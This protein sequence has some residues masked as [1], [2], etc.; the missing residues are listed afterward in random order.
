MRRTTTSLL[1]AA[2][3]LLAGAARPAVAQ[4]SVGVPP[5]LLTWRCGSIVTEF[6]AACGQS[7]VAPTSYPILH[8]FTFDIATTS[9]LQF[10]IFEHAAVMSGAAL[11]EQAIAPTGTD[12]APW[13]ATPLG[14]LTLTPGTLYLALIFMDPGEQVVFRANPNDVY[15]DGQWMGC[16]VRDHGFACRNPGVAVAGHD[17]AFTATFIS[18]QTTAPEPATLALIGSGLFALGGVHA[19]KRKR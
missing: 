8:S 17:A 5:A 16:T 2:V 6:A 7:F 19:R 14:G 13:T 1:A 4:I 15:T 3:A 10:R 12:S 9:T 18:A 11:F